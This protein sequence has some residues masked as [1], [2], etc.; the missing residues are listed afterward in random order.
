MSFGQTYE[1]GYHN[2]RET[3]KQ[4]WDQMQRNLEGDARKM[5]KRGK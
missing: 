5:G 3:G 1:D 4:S 2:G